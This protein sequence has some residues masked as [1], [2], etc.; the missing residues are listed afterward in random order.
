MVAYNSSRPN[1]AQCRRIG[2][3]LGKLALLQAAT[4]PA[5]AQRCRICRGRWAPRRV[6][7]GGCRRWS[8]RARAACP[9]CWSTASRTKNPDGGDAS[10]GSSVLGKLTGSG[11]AKKDSGFMA[12]SKGM[13]DTGGG[14][15]IGLG[16]QGIKAKVTD[17]VCDLVLEHAQSLLSFSQGASPILPPVR[18]RKNHNIRDF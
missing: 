1:P 5:S 17:Q 11:Q 7:A 8:R 14:E 9:V 2:I 3:A 12:S 4:A 6:A 10:A 16:G 15:T 18:R 13:L